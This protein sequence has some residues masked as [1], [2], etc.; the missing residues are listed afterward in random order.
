MKS[1]SLSQILS[2]IPFLDTLYCCPLHQRKVPC[3]W[4]VTCATL[5]LAASTPATLPSLARP[6][7]LLQAFLDVAF[8]AM[9]SSSIW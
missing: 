3:Q 6:S 5:A 8:L 2:F 9:F 4:L 7:P 1:P